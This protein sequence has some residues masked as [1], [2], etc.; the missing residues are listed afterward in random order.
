MHWLR[1]HQRPSIPA[2]IYDVMAGILLVR[3]AGGRVTDYAGRESDL[4]TS[5]QQVL[6]SNGLIHD[7]MLKV[8]REAR[9]GL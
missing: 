7:A 5:G 9:A 8:L 2:T 3:E 6:S 4:V 1:Y